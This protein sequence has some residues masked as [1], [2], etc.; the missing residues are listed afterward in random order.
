MQGLFSGAGWIAY[1]CKKSITI[2][3]TYFQSFSQVL[4]SGLVK[5]IMTKFAHVLEQSLD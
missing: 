2:M 1:L 3:S 4:A 5:L